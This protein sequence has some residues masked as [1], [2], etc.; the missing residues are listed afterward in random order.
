[1]HGRARWRAHARHDMVRPHR[2]ERLQLNDTTLP[3]QKTGLEQAADRAAD[4][5]QAGSEPL[6]RGEYLKTFSVLRRTSRDYLLPTRTE[7]RRVG[8]GGL[9]RVRYRGCPSY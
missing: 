4:E 7:E 9:R 6:P 1:M 2:S 3:G 5:H 8:K